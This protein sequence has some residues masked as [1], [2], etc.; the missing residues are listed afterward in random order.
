MA[1]NFLKAAIE[2]IENDKRIS[3]W[4]IF[5]LIYI[6]SFLRGFLENYANFDNENRVMGV[7]DTF[8]HYPFWFFGI[9]IS[10]FILLSLFTKERIEKVSRLGAIFSF[11]I[12][13][14]PIFDLIVNM[15]VQARYSFIVGSFSDLTRS[16]FTFFGGVAGGTYGATVGMKIEIALAIL[17]VGFYIFHK[18]KKIFRAFIGALALYVIIF[19][20]ISTPTFIFVA[21]NVFSVDKQEITYQTINNFY[22]IQE[23]EHSFTKN[24]TFIVENKNNNLSL[25]QSINNVYSATI[26]IIFLVLDILLLGWWFWLYGT[27]KF[28]ATIKNFRFLRIAHYFLMAFAGIYFGIRFSGQNPVSSLFDFASLISLFMCLL[29]SWLFAVWENDEADTEIDKI[30][31]S[32]RPLIENALDIGEWHILKYLFLFIALSF[33]FLGGFYLFIFAVLF[34]CLY[35]IYSIYPLR[36]KRFFGLS[37]LVIACNA[38]IAVLMGFFMFSGTENLQKFPNRYFWGILIIFFLA[39]HIKNLKDFEGDK[40]NNIQTLPVMLGFKNGKLIT[41]VLVFFAALLAPIF[42]YFNIVTF[43]TAVFFGLALFF[44]INA[45]KFKEKYVFVIYFIFAVIFAGEAV[46]FSSADS[47]DARANQAAMAGWNWLYQYN[48]NFSDPGIPLIIKTINDKYCYS[49]KAETFWKGVLKE[50]ENHSYLPVFE[51]FFFNKADYEKISNKALTILKTPQAYYNDVLP[52]ALYCDLY[53]VRKD[54]AVN[55]FDKIGEETSYDLTHK[56]WSAVLFKENGCI[57]EDYNIDEVISVAAKKMAA[58]QDVSKEFNDLYAER[59]AFLEY[60]GFKNL[61]KEEWIK[62]IIDNQLE[63]G[64]WSNAVKGVGN[65]HTTALSIWALAE[66]SATCPFQE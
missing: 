2:K 11:I 54:F 56:F 25:T 47:F 40:E 20:F 35:H 31:N 37:S 41:G 8:F 33:A 44:T 38:L 7:I 6:A 36:L 52:Q 28:I 61:V 27:K 63:S 26:S 3:F 55:A 48:N 42:F 45:E 19:L 12:I 66:H 18:T 62:N 43:L 17:A 15:G 14:P 46:V 9:F 24:R 39:E 50:F 5:S 34:L 29:F 21:K 23:L 65:P 49:S 64:G 22:S 30:S 16:F 4:T 60:Y 59:T 53:P 1:V 57:T 51:R 32:N 10:A 13:S 58:D